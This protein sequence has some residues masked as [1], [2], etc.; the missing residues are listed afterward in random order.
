MYRA[1]V[2]SWNLRDRHMASTLDALVSHLDHQLGRAR[3]VVW[4][5]NS[6]VGDA[7][8]T[9]MG[10]AGELNVGQLVRTRW[11]SDCVLVGFTTHHGRVT[12]ASDW[13]GPA[14]RKHVRPALD[15]SYE[16]L[17]HQASSTSSSSASRGEA[18]GPPARAAARAG[19]RGDL[20]AADGA[21][22]PLV[23]RPAAGPVRCRH[24]PRPHHRRRAVGANG[25]VGRRRTARDLPD[26]PLVGADRG[27]RPGQ[28]SSGRS[29]HVARYGARPPM[30]ASHS[31]R[32]TLRPARRQAAAT[33][34][35]GGSAPDFGGLGL[36]SGERVAVT[37]SNGCRISVRV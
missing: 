27:A 4:E 28:L 24:P 1:E 37:W 18:R 32:V 31:S 22:Q 6:H 2:S 26:R 21:G 25:A 9:D 20:P 7:R 8:A 5:H 12:A 35:S 17:F 30:F 14:E 19:H 10:A 15:G 23:P 13:G 3:V 11:P 34:C 16:Q 29:G 33:Q 36:V